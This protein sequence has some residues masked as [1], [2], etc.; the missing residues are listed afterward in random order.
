MLRKLV[1]YYIPYFL[2]TKELIKCGRI[3]AFDAV[4]MIV[5]LPLNLYSPLDSEKNLINLTQFLF[6]SKLYQRL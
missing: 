3:S 5:N 4:T 2:L 1:A 6:A